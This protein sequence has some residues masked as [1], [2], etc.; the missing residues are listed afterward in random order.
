MK[1]YYKMPEETAT[2]IDADG[3]LHSGDIGIMDE[4]GYCRITGRIKD[5]IIRGGENIYPKEIEEFLHT[6]ARGLRRA[7]RAGV[8][9]RKY[10][11]EVGG[12]RIRK[13]GRRHDR[14]RCPGVLPGPDRQLQD[15]ALRHLRDRLSR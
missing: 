8:P 1:G 14:D 9:T 6:H 4:D 11:E 5:M 7:G 12:L 13:A 3:W 15:P 10:G 2:A